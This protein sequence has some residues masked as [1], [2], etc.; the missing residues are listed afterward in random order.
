MGCQC[1]GMRELE[2][3]SGQDNDQFFLILFAASLI[4]FLR[5]RPRFVG[6]VVVCWRSASLSSDPSLFDDSSPSVSYSDVAFDFPF[7]ARSGVGPRFA[8]DEEA[9]GVSIGM[10][11]LG[12]CGV[13]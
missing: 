10:L 11:G 4:I 7:V 3:R 13:D 9:C 1:H 6:G 5:G 8:M 12:A 2:S